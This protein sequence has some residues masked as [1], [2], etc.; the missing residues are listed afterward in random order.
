MEIHKPKPWRGWREF[1]KEYLIIVVGVLTALA[2]EQVVEWLHW[3]HVAHEAEARLAAGLQ[4]DLINAAEWLAMEPCLRQRL[5]GLATELAKPGPAWKA[6][7]Q[8]LP[9]GFRPPNAMPL[10][11]LGL[12]RLWN[13]VAWDTALGS[14]VLNHMAPE[15]VDTYAEVYRLVDFMR[16]HQPAILVVQARLA[17][18]G[19]DRNLSEAERTAF[20]AQSA[21]VAALHNSM[22]NSARQVLRDAHAIGI[23]PSRPGLAR[24]VTRDRAVAGA[25]V[26]DPKL[27]LA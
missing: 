27:P 6:N 19:Y 11:L 16:E 18:L 2:G 26:V 13:H 14:G 10:V 5:S 15:R 22:L 7:I 24:R 20:I 23:E 8:P 25:C 12:S 4:G 21:E 1:L 3:R 9:A 17:P